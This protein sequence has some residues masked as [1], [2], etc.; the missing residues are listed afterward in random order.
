M[1]RELSNLVSELAAV[2][3]RHLQNYHPLKLETVLIS[4]SEGLPVHH[5][6]PRALRVAQDSVSGAPLRP[7][8][9]PEMR[10]QGNRKSPKGS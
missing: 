8:L 10:G 9:S 4:C 3:S 5:Q 7:C 1:R 2:C 6:V